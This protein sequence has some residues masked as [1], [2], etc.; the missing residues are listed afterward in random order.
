VLPA[1]SNFLAGVSPAV[2]KGAAAQPRLAA[3]ADSPSIGTATPIPACPVGQCP[4]QSCHC[5]LTST[6]PYEPNGTCAHLHCTWV[7]VPCTATY[8][9]DHP[10]GTGVN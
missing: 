10:V 8:D 2:L 7:C 4:Y 1:S 5:S 6:N 3:S 9:Q